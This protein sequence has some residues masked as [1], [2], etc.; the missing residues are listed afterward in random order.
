MTQL[1]KI[2]QL[3]IS[4]FGVSDVLISIEYLFDCI[5][6]MSLFVSNLVDLTIG[7]FAEKAEDFEGFIDMIVDFRLIF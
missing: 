7:A 2:V 6:L 1:E 3:T 4:T 5:D